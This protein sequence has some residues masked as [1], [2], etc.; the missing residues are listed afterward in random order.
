MLRREYWIRSKD[1]LAWCEPDELQILSKQAQ[2]ALNERMDAYL[3]KL[4]AKDRAKK[5]ARAK[6]I[7]TVMIN[8]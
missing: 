5:K 8:N 6:K 3:G 4:D 1:L 2:K 7:K